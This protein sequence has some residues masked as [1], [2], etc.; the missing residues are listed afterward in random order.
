MPKLYRKH[1][2]KTV[3]GCLPLLIQM[4]NRSPCTPC[5]ATLWALP[6]EAV[7]DPGPDCG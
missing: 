1:R 7:L 5:S 2:A 6:S 4:V 3:G